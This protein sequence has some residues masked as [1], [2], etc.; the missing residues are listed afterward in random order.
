MNGHVDDYGR[1]LVRVAVWHPTS[2][3]SAEWDAWIDTGFSGELLLTKDQVAAL[4]LTVTSRVSGAVADGSQVQFD[5]CVCLND[6]LGVRRRV[7]ALV[8]SGRF[9]LIGIRLLEDL[10]VTVNY[11]KQ[12]VELAHSAGVA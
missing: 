10:T 11:P 8:S 4:G 1:A 6:W 2:G 5:A 9:A 12:T 3:S 7:D